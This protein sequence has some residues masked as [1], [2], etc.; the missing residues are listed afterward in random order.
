VVE[1]PSIVFRKKILKNDKI[2]VVRLE[3][4]FWAENK[5][6]LSLSL[7]L[8]TIGISLDFGLGLWRLHTM[9]G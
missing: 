2:L 1:R 9:P 7:S 6:K 5:V 3:G 4:L 8:S